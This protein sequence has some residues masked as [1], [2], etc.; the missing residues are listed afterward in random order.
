MAGNRKDDARELGSSN[1]G[2]GKTDIPGE[3]PMDSGTETGGMATAGSGLAGTSGGLG[4][5]GGSAVNRGSSGGT[6]GNAGNLG[7][8]KG[9]APGRGAGTDVGVNDKGSPT[10]SAVGKGEGWADSDPKANP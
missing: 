3:G 6:G 9:T 1:L 8:G 4:T 5:T 2:Q 7:V 10:A